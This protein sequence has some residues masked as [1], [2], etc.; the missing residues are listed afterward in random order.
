MERHGEAWGDMGPTAASACF[1]PPPLDTRRKSGRCFAIGRKRDAASS[2]VTGR[3]EVAACAA[4]A[5]RLARKVRPSLVLNEWP[6]G[7]IACRRGPEDG[8]AAGEACSA[9]VATAST[10]SVASGPCPRRTR[11]IRCSEASSRCRSRAPATAGTSVGA[12]VAPAW[13]GSFSSDSRTRRGAAGPLGFFSLKVARACRPRA[14]AC[15]RAA[16]ACSSPEGWSFEPVTASCAAGGACSLAPEAAA[17]RA[18]D[19][20]MA[21]IVAASTSSRANASRLDA[22]SGRAPGGPSSPSGPASAGPGGE[23]GGE[24]AGPF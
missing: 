20:A 19:T 6:R 7:G 17:S 2:G 4:A 21:E 10:I 9:A 24:G 15:T 18:S 3:G 12:G 1:A 8:A 11:R 23:G 16:A 14:T 22:S 13:G 5:A